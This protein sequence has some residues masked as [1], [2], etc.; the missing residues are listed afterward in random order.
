M[1]CLSKK[2]IYFQSIKWRPIFLLCVL[3]LSALLLKR[4]FQSAPRL[5]VF[6]RGLLA[7]SNV[8]G[9]SKDGIMSMKNRNTGKNG[10]LVCEP[11]GGFGNKVRVIASCYKLAE[12]LDRKLIVLNTFSKRTCNISRHFNFTT[13]PIMGRD[14]NLTYGK[15]VILTYEMIQDKE[16]CLKDIIHSQ[17]KVIKLAAYHNF[18]MHC[19]AGNRELQNRFLPEALEF[20]RMAYRQ[21]FENLFQPTT[22]F[23]EVLKGHTDVILTKKPKDKMLCLHIRSGLVK[24]DSANIVSKSCLIRYM[25]KVRK[26]VRYTSD[27]KSIFL[28][29]DNVNITNFVYRHSPN[30]RLTHT[31]PG[32]VGHSSRHNVNC[33]DMDKLL[34]EFWLMKH[35]DYGLFLSSSSFSYY[36]ILRSAHLKELSIFNCHKNDL[37]ETPKSKEKYWVLK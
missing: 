20:N 16:T 10:I 11:S 23:N 32:N 22:K 2:F 8:F 12:I 6:K 35:C 1:N 31:I 7:S 5:E 17:A 13:L 36:G 26:F 21:V 24:H 30:K 28:A 37:T 25:M 33:K 18:W 4:S 27:I 19:I 3:I 34:S 15:Q 9:S 29:S 14:S